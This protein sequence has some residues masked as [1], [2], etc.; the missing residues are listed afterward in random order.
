M[1]WKKTPEKLRKMFPL[2]SSVVHKHIMI[3]LENIVW[4]EDPNCRM[5][6]TGG[7]DP[8]SY[9]WKYSPKNKK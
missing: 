6:K 7:A 4:R 8:I 2:E 9:P 3:F 1:V 5:P